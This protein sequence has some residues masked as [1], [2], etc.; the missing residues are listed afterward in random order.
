M[1]YL[2]MFWLSIYK[3]ILL[4]WFCKKFSGSACS[5]ETETQVF[6]W[7]FFTET[8]R[9]EIVNEICWSKN[10]EKLVTAH[11]Q[12]RKII[13]FEIPS[14]KILIFNSNLDS[15]PPSFC[16]QNIAYRLIF[17]RTEHFKASKFYYFLTYDCRNYKTDDQNF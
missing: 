8:L 5:Y 17:Q 12:Y 7:V 6:L 1:F 10:T 2:R 16:F 11:H 13:N 15:K 4:I 9:S 14:K 3:E